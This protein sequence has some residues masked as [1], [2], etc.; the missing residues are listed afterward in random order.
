MGL[1]QSGKV[2]QQF[3]IRRHLFPN[4]RPEDLQ[5][6]MLATGQFRAVHLGHGSC[7]HGDLVDPLE[8]C[9]ELWAEFLLEDCRHA[10]LSRPR[11]RRHVALQFFQFLH[12]VLRDQ[13]RAGAH[14][15]S[16]LDKRRPQALEKQSDANRDRLRSILAGMLRP[17]VVMAAQPG[18]TGEFSK[19]KTQQCGDD[20]RPALRRRD[21][22]ESAQTKT[23]ARR[24]LRSSFWIRLHRSRDLFV[25]RWNSG[26]SS[27]AFH[28]KD[29]LCGCCAAN[30]GFHRAT[31]KTSRAAAPRIT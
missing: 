18:L 3:Q 8:L 14:D 28:G 6:H 19:S 16:D 12:P 9:L 5:D 2:S 11:S 20:L 17:L 24:R 15:L 26:A 29:L 1:H 27:G 22:V 25:D 30:R 10:G 31:M 21:G 13:V 7:R 23:C 4:A